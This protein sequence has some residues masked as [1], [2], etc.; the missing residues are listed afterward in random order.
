MEMVFKFGKYLK[1]INLNYYKLLLT[2][3]IFS[4][5][6][7]YINCEV[8]AIPAKY[9]VKPRAYGFQ[10]DSPY[11]DLFNYMLNK[12]K[13][14]GTYDKIAAKYEPPPQVCPDT[15]GQQLGFNSCITLFLIILAGYSAC[16]CILFIECMLHYLYPEITWFSSVPPIPPPES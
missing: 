16:I 9:D 7:E 11:L 4:T 14:E 10:K 2:G 12:M 5:Y 3:Y 1:S 6:Q 8:I 13:E 15:S